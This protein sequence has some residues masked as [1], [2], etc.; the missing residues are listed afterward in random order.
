[1]YVFN[2]CPA[3]AAARIDTNQLRL[4]M[5][6]VFLSAHQRVILLGRMMAICFALAFAEY[7]RSLIGAVDRRCHPASA[8]HACWYLGLG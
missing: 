2:D 8:T 7:C 6:C 4:L 5:L 1:M 3:L